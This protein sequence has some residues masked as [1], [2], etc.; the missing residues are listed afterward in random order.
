MA[1]IRGMQS[2]ANVD[3][4]ELAALRTL[5]ARF[6]PVG[7]CYTS[8]YNCVGQTVPHTFEIGGHTVASGTTS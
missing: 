2:D 1:Q 6:A 4:H 8:G 3:E 5:Y 7:Q